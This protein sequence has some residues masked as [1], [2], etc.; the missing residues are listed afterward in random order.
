[1]WTTPNGPIGE[2]RAGRL[3][4]VWSTSRHLLITFFSN[5]DAR[6]VKNFRSTVP[7][8]SLDPSCDQPTQRM[9]LSSP[10]QA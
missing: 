7:I 2:G 1:M 10:S 3:L 4:S 9:A 5:D 8:S 6:A